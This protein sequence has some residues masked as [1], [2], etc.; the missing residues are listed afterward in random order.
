MSKHPDACNKCGKW[1]DGRLDCS[2]SPDNKQSLRQQVNKRLDFFTEP[3]KGKVYL[4]DLEDELVFLAESH[5]RAARI[6]ELDKLID[7]NNETFNRWSQR[8]IAN[9][10]DVVGRRYRELDAKRTIRKIRTVQHICQ[11][12]QLT[13]HFVDTQSEDV[14]KPVD[15]DTINADETTKNILLT[16]SDIELEKL[17]AEINFELDKRAQDYM[18]ENEG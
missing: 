9:F 18:K 2:P 8:D 10:F 5:T 14:N 6:D 13:P 16:R 1:H 4:K 11:P 15:K 12:E 17:G 3:G 7:I